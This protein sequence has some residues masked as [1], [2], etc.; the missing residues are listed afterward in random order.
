MTPDESAARGPC[1]VCRGSG[2]EP[3]TATTTV[4]RCGYCLGTG[5]VWTIQNREQ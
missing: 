1:P 4:S 3:T 2:I 5:M